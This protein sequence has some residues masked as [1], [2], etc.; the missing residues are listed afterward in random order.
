MK[1]KKNNNYD[2]TDKYTEI[3]YNISYYRKHANLTQE[4][5][6]ELVGISRSH[7]SAIEAPN[8]NR[9]VSMELVL[10]IAD[11]LHIDAY[12]LLKMRD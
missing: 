11:A 7:L 1:R 3:G 2:H 6:A 9:S 12:Q 10:D 8:V 5:L 4:Q